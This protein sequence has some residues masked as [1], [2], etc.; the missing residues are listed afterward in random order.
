MKVV[1]YGVELSDNQHNK[2]VK[3]KEVSYE[4][5]DKFNDSR[6]ICSLMK[7][8]FK[9]HKK[10]EEHVYLLSFNSNMNLLGVFEVSHGG[11]KES[12]A[13]NRSIFVRAVL[14]GAAY[15]ILVHNHPSGNASPSKQDIHI[16]S[17]IKEAGKLMDIPL[18]DHIIIAG[19]EYYSF[20]ES[21]LIIE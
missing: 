15:I 6:E 20:K 14:S 11:V 9:L 3:E 16:T 5:C 10:A 2:L 13:S 18:L 12:F 7:D 4:E 21:N 17:Q 1:T 19:E 8:V